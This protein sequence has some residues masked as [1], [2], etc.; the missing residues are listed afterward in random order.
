MRLLPAIL[1]CLAT[2]ALAQEAPVPNE[3]PVDPA[4]VTEAAS[5][6]P[7]EILAPLPRRRP[8]PGLRAEPDASDPPAAEPQR[9]YQAACPALMSGQVRGRVLDAIDEGPCGERSPLAVGAVLVNGRMVPLS[10]EAIVTCGM[11]AAL[12]GWAATIES[13]LAARESTRLAGI[14]VGTSYACRLRNNAAAGAMSEHG[15]ANALDVTGFEL[16]DGRTFALPAGW[17]DPASPAGRLL[18][19]AHEAACASFTTTLGPEANALH[20]DHLHIDLGCHG[21]RCT[22]RLCE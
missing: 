2:G 15:F 21:S 8:S 19:Y 10:S 16:E 5:G 20:A 3:R 4:A 9:T 7:D 22:A 14:V 18:R 6:A 17:T 13:Y 11:A 12:P 1:V